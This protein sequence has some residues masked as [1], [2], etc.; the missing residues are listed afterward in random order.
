MKGEVPKPTAEII[1]FQEVKLERLRGSINEAL[2]DFKE[3]VGV[4]EKTALIGAEAWTIQRH[5]VEAYV[6]D[7]EESDET[8]VTFTLGIKLKTSGDY[9]WKFKEDNYVGMLMG[10]INSM[11]RGLNGTDEKAHYVSIIQSRK[12]KLRSALRVSYNP[13]RLPIN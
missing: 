5:P 9:I 13:D 2:E 3:R 7:E 6:I 8:S 4:I 10:L 11:L 1:N 12:N